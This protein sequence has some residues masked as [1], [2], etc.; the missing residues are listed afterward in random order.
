MVDRQRG[1]IR[2][3][4]M[5]IRPPIERLVVQLDDQIGGQDRIAIDE[6]SIVKVQREV[7]RSVE[8][9]DGQKV[10]TLRSSTKTKSQFVGNLRE[11]FVN[12]R[13][14]QTAAVAFERARGQT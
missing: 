10:G 2:P 4:Q 6:V 5:K 1:E 13:G 11:I 14:D 9:L 3:E 8:I 12:Q 7:V